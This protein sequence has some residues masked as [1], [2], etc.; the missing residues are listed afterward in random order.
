MIK[1]FGIKH[2]DNRQ[3]LKDFLEKMYDDQNKLKR[4]EIFFGYN[5]S[6]NNERPCDDKIFYDE[7]Q[8]DEERWY[9]FDEQQKEHI[10]DYDNLSNAKKK[11]MNKIIVD[12]LN[13]FLEKNNA[14]YS[15]S[16]LVD[17]FIYGEQYGKGMLDIAKNSLYFNNE[18]N[19][20]SLFFKNKGKFLEAGQKNKQHYS[21]TVQTLLSLFGINLEICGKKELMA[22]LYVNI[23]YLLTER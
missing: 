4:F 23:L 6:T 9:H 2:T 12:I 8:S 15:S 22:S 17:V 1:S 21:K 3:L 19:N 10:D 13:R 7:G 11:L 18:E 20:R 16:Q 14:K 5:K